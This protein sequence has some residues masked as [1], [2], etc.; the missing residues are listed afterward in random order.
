MAQAMGVALADD[1]IANAARILDVLLPYGTS[2]NRVGLR[3]GRAYSIFVGQILKADG[4]VNKPT[5]A[6]AIR[7][8]DL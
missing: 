6:D 1:V 3:S 7:R 4:D 5:R 8:S 2:Q